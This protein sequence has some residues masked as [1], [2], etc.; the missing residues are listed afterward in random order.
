M[1]LVALQKTQTEVDFHDRAPELALVAIVSLSA[2][3][4][5]RKS[6]GD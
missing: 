4:A 3:I 1:E 5:R 2:R 6:M